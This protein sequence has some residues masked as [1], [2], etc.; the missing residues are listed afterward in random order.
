MLLISALMW[1]MFEFEIQY[2]SDHLISVCVYVSLV[3]IC[4]GKTQMQS[5]NKWDHEIKEVFLRRMNNEKI[6]S[7]VLC[8]H[9]QS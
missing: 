2:T 9:S 6:V 3:E 1:V 4:R 5:I 8:F 7:R